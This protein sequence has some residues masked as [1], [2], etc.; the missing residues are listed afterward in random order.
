[1]HRNNALVSSRIVSRARR[2]FSLALRCPPHG[3]NVPKRPNA[4]GYRHPPRKAPPSKR[5][6]RRAQPRHRRRLRTAVTRASSSKRGASAFPPDPPTSQP[7]SLPLPLATVTTLRSAA[8]PGPGP[9]SPPPLAIALISVELPSVAMSWGALGQDPCVSQPLAALPSQS[10]KP[11]VHAACPHT[12]AAQVAA[13]CC[14]AQT[15]PHAP[16]LR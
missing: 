3:T 12:P 6:P 7:L 13:A 11:L 15:A 4:A 10:E 14:T 5:L 1:M 8:P 16:Q 2:A 9:A